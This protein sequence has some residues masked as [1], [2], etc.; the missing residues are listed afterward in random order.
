MMWIITGVLSFPRKGKARRISDTY[1][2]PSAE[3]VRTIDYLPSLLSLWS[4]VQSPPA[5]PK[6][7]RHSLVRLAST[8]RKRHL[9]TRILDTIWTPEPEV[10]L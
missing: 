3:K 5:S 6:I 2:T 7:Q 10:R 9:F 4:R 8:R 1:R